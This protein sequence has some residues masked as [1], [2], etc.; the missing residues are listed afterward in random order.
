MNKRQ[1]GIV[2]KYELKYYNIDLKLYRED[3]KLYK[4]ELLKKIINEYRRGFIVTKINKPT[5]KYGTKV[6]YEKIKSFQESKKK[7]EEIINKLK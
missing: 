4:K 1:I 2:L 3:E 5:H 6:R 7:F